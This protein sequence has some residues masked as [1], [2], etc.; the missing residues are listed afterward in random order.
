M[1]IPHWQRLVARM[2]CEQVVGVPDNQRNVDPEL[3][4]AA[5]E[6]GQLWALEWEYP[7]VVETP[8]KVADEVG[9]ILDMW[10]VI[11]NAYSE[12][13]KSEQDE[14]RKATES[15]SIGFTG[16]DANTEHDHYAAGCFMVEK[17]ERFSEFKSR[18]NSHSMDSVKQNM[19]IYQRYKRL[20]ERRA[21]T[22][23]KDQLIA[24]LRWWDEL[25][26]D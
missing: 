20:V 2:L 8:A 1:S 21:S 13:S 14:V 6:Q 16:F 12:L 3:V 9:E 26:G 19:R 25:G 18:L 15:T 5:L 24:I 17:L 4:L 23:S 11:E 22:L 10:R 7:E